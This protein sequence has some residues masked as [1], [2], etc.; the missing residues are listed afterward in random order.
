[1]SEEFGAARVTGKAATLPNDAC[2]SRAPGKHKSYFRERA[3][4]TREKEHLSNG[5]V[6]APTEV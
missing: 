3:R 1:M 2:T 6:V 5:Y 4:A